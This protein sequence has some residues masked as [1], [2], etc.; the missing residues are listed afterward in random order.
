MHIDAV[1]EILGAVRALGI[2]RKGVR[3][4]PE[5]R[6]NLAC[7]DLGAGSGKTVLALALLHPFERIVGVEQVGDS[8]RHENNLSL[9]FLRPFGTAI[10]V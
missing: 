8:P 5:E 7:W 4:H 6:S 1:S 9:A 3:P 10:G 2:M